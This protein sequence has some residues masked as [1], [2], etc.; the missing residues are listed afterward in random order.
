MVESLFVL[1]YF[2]FLLLIIR[3]IM[4]ENYKKEL[5]EEKE[6]HI[7]FKNTSLKDFLKT[8]YK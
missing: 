7:I 1:S 4:D 5:K 2:Y 8:I 3:N 6:S